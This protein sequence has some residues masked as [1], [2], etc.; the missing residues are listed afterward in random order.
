M[1]EEIKTEVNS[2]EEVRA[3]VG[4]TSPIKEK[5]TMFG[6]DEFTKN[7][8]I[9]RKSNLGDLLLGDNKRFTTVMSFDKVCTKSYCV[10]EWYHI[11]LNKTVNLNERFKLNK[12]D[13][14]TSKNKLIIKKDVEIIFKDAD[15][16]DFPTHI[17]SDNF[18]LIGNS[19][20]Y[21]INMDT[22]KFFI[23]INSCTGNVYTKMKYKSGD[24][25]IEPK[26]YI[27]CLFSTEQY[28]T[29]LEKERDEYINSLAKVDEKGINPMASMI[30]IIHPSEDETVKS[31]FKNDQVLKSKY[32]SAVISWLKNRKLDKRFFCYKFKPGFLIDV[33][34]SDDIDAKDKTFDTKALVAI[35]APDFIKDI[36]KAVPDIECDESGTPVL[37]E[38]DFKSLEFA[39][40]KKDNANMIYNTS[41]KIIKESNDKIKD[42]TA[43]LEDHEFANKAFDASCNLCLELTDLDNFYDKLFV[44]GRVFAVPYTANETIAEYSQELSEYYILD[45]KNKYE[46]DIENANKTI[47][48]Q[49]EG[50]ASLQLMSRY[51]IRKQMEDGTFKNYHSFTSAMLFFTAMKREKIVYEKNGKDNFGAL[52]AFFKYANKKIGFNYHADKKDLANGYY[53]TRIKNTLFGEFE[54]SYFSS[55]RNFVGCSLPIV[56]KLDDTNKS[57]FITRIITDI[58][59]KN[60]YIESMSSYPIKYLMLI[61][62][63]LNELVEFDESKYDKLRTDG[64]TEIQK[65]L[66][67]M[68]YH[69]EEFKDAIEYIDSGVREKL[70][71][72][73][74][75]INEKY[76]VIVEWCGTVLNLMKTKFDIIS[77]RKLKSVPNYIASSCDIV[78]VSSITKYLDA[79]VYKKTIDIVDGKE[80]E[81]ELDEF[82]VK[83]I[84]M[85]FFLELVAKE[86]L[87]SAYNRLYDS[88]DAVGDTIK[89]L[90]SKDMV[91][92]FATTIGTIVACDEIISKF[93]DDPVNNNEGIIDFFD[94]S[95]KKIVGKDALA[96]IVS[97]L[98]GKIE[99]DEPELSD[100]LD[101][102][103]GKDIDST[104]YIIAR[105]PVAE[106][107]V[108]KSNRTR[109]TVARDRL[110]IDCANITDMNLDITLACLKAITEKL[111]E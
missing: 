92:F 5:R 34:T 87:I 100:S 54:S 33:E 90:K 84:I 30:N 31:K 59:A 94:T 91:T 27:F 45:S 29:E 53:G 57:E 93:R 13:A 109:L 68:D 111:P 51:Q 96:V 43:I 70:S 25:W 98:S 3:E 47:D 107:T 52:N 28:E 32:G 64:Y 106:D 103:Y 50:L 49:R 67:K 89:G 104:N 102:T 7:E 15:I 63:T 72:I 108:I 56:S 6:K 83:N 41:L 65:R 26:G 39:G 11:P 22:K 80:K 78:T 97:G 55:L 24:K 62:R 48:E 23:S 86:T 82:G 73:R 17:S 77:E 110:F 19:Y 105:K 21:V 14:I 99:D 8:F 2:N 42:S 76:N 74:S 40:I 58:N 1:V 4:E 35:L 66:D 20:V 38:N 88:M 46:K 60:T 71:E 101:V 69:P 95:H 36:I 16:T 12:A 81:I 44:D 9:F 10:D 18:V 79:I 75:L 37:T 61:D 85:K